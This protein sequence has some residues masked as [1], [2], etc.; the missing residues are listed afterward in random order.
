[1]N[2]DTILASQPETGICLLQLARPHNMNALSVPALY[3]AHV[4][5]D[6]VLNDRSLR[7]IVLTGQGRGFCA[8]LDLKSLL[9]QDA[10]V[11]WT[12]EE[13]MELQRLFAGLVLRLHQSDTPVIAA[14]NGVAVGAGMALA[15][16]ADVRF[17]AQEASFHVGAVKIGLS[18]GECGISYHLPRLVGAG[19]AFEIMLSGRAVD[20]YEAERIGLVSQVL[21]SSEL[22]ARAMECARQVRA[23]AP[24][25]ATSTKRIMW[26]N[27]DA[28]DVATAMAHENQV[29]VLGLMTHDFSEAVQAF[30]QKRPPRFASS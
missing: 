7:A 9:E 26:R 10:R 16:A 2:T 15:L 11:S 27:L 23:L 30:A 1:M 21:A 12:V 17:A 8:G 24:Y 28:P 22:L 3:G 14:V 4:M 25:S 6:Q 13:A 5:L 18:A 29:Q 20:A 19:R